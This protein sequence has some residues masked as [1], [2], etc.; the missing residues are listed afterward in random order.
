MTEKTINADNRKNSII[1]FSALFIGL[2]LGYLGNNSLNNVFDFVATVFTRLFSFIAIPV[3]AFT[4]INTLANLGANKESKLIF[5]KTVFY[6]VLT[7]LLSAFLALIIYL[8]F[9]PE[10]LGGDIANF[11]NNITTSYKE[12]FLSVI[13]NNLLQPFLAGNVLSV[14]FIAAAF[15]MA[16]SVMRECEEKKVLLAFFAGVQKLLFILIKWL[17]AILPLGILAFSGQLAAQMKTG[18]VVGSL[19]TYFSA[20]ISANLIQMFFII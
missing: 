11:E 3:I 18:V 2:F 7:T 12:H 1:Y 14:L 9:S 10:K 20:V 16:L 5:K 6:T 19:A 15:G 17:I 13:P 4:L 8:I